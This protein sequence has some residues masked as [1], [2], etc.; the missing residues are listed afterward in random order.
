MKVA[1][2]SKNVNYYGG[3]E[4]YHS[5]LKH[6]VEKCFGK[7]DIFV[8]PKINNNWVNIFLTKL[9]AGSFFTR[10]LQMNLKE[11][12]LVICNGEHGWGIF[13]PKCICIY[14]GTYLGQ[15]KY[16]KDGLRL[17]SVIRLEILAYIQKLAA[18]K[19]FIVSVSELTRNLLN[20]Q[21]IKTNY[22]LTGPVCIDSCNTKK[23]LFHNNRILAVA[24]HDYYGKGFDILEKLTDQGFKIDCVT[25]KN[26]G[27]KLK[28]LHI[29]NHKE[30]MSLYK[31][32]FILVFPSR[33]EGFPLVPLEA[34]A[35]GLP[36]II[37]DIGY[38]EELK[39]EIP[40]FFVKNNSIE[41]FVAAIN[42]IKIN[43]EYYS[44]KAFDYVKTHHNFSIFEQNV[45]RMIDQVLSSN[46]N[47]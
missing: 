13:H 1:I 16:L 7:V 33:Y 37:N 23:N 42:E 15:I 20:Q 11:Y 24:R 17:K 26:P 25:N 41:E 14:H 36:V 19:K 21:K 4:V 31:D 6:I 3:V 39:A 12:D 22:I 45:I 9:T 35:A 44:K 38:Y 8:P 5:Y 46:E 30:I 28:W 47:E 29:R 43:Y 32:Y 40:E 34:M 18:R 2:I 27:Q 10:K